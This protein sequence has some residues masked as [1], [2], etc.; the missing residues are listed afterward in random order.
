[1]TNAIRG[2]TE[3]RPAQMLV[4]H[5]T[6]HYAITSLLWCVALVA[7]FAPLAIRAYRKL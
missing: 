1:M 6:G 3:G 4:E 5:S 2:L 7:V